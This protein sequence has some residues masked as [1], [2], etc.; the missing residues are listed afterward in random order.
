M[1]EPCALPLPDWVAEEVRTTPAST[2]LN[3][4]VDVPPQWWREELEGR[5]LGDE[6]FDAPNDQLTRAQLFELGKQAAESAGGARRL[7][8]ATLAWGTGR[9]H[10]NN[11]SR[12]K[13]VTESLDACSE[14]LRRA[15]ELKI[16][17]G[18]CY[19]NDPNSKPVLARK[20]TSSPGRYCIR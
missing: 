20:P 14:T 2:V 11:H 18:G 13:A 9:R 16:I 7:L 15:A 17:K 19:R 5:G 4:A 1:N 12:I 8:W 10:R 3:Q 6:L